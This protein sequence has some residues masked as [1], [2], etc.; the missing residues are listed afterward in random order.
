MKNQDL[1]KNLQK[2]VTDEFCKPLP[3]EQKEECI[4]YYEEWIPDEE[5]PTGESKK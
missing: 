2:E 1:M 5:E 3:G 4:N